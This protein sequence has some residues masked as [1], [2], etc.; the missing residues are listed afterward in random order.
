[1]TLRTELDRYYDRLLAAQRHSAVVDL[2]GDI[3]LGGDAVER[4]VARLAA[5]AD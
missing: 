2:L 3:R 4:D 1:M 5:V